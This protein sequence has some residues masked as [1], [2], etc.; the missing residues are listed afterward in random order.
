[1][2]TLFLSRL[3]FPISTLGP[4]RRLGIW[5]QGCSIRCPGC[6]SVDTWTPGLGATTVERVLASIAEWL[7]E[8]DGV[9]ISGG[10]PFDQ[11]AAL[12]ELLQGLRKHPDVDVLVYS[13]HALESLDLSGFSGHIDALIC[14]PFDAS[15]DQSLA[16]R[17]SD[18]QRLIPLTS[19]G[20]QRFGA[21]VNAPADAK[22]LDLMYDHSSGEFFLAGVP[23]RGD[24]HRLASLLKA[25]G[26]PTWTTE[27]RRTR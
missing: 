22:T 18:N 10:E 13:G 26:H 11:P 20:R 8:A 14:D 23:Q 6:I 3:H 17:G 25:N 15:R 7:G 4:G 19:L 9:T 27:D 16:L 1:M 12:L 24:F 2:T 5:F 21:L